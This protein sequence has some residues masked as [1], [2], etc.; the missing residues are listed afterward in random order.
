MRNRKSRAHARISIDSPKA[1]KTGGLNGGWC[2]LL[3]TILRVKF[4]DQQGKY[5]EFLRFWSSGGQLAAKIPCLLWVFFGI[6][7]S[8]EQGI[9]KCEQGIILLEQGI[10]VEQQGSRFQV[11]STGHPG[12]TG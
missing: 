10:L 8:T 4:P 3:R 7:Y 5:R 1:A 11:H 6:P 12:T 2:S 9:L